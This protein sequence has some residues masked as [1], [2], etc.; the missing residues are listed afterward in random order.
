M[1]IIERHILRH[2]ENIKNHCFESHLLLRVIT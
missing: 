2:K 1:D